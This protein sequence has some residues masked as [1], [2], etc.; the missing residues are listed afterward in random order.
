[1]APSRRGSSPRRGAGREAP[2]GLRAKPECALVS[3]TLRFVTPRSIKD[4]LVDGRRNGEG[5]LGATVATGS[6]G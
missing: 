3:W 1:M 2:V 5:V 4:S 6:N